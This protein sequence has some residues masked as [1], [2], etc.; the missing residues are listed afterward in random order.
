MTRRAIAIGGV[1]L[2]ALIGGSRADGDEPAVRHFRDEV[3]PIL[4]SHCLECHGEGKAG[5]LDLRTHQSALAGGNSGAAIVPNASKES[6]LYQKV[7][8]GEMPPQQPL[9]AAEIEVLK[10]W[11]DR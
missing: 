9:G 4:L 8:A 11:I 2:V 1:M 3:R 6:L 5:G 7:A 10:K